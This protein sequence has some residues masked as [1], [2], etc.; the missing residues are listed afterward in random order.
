MTNSWIYRRRYACEIRYRH[1]GSSAL[2]PHINVNIDESVNVFGTATGPAVIPTEVT[3]LPDDNVLFFSSMQER[4]QHM[5][6]QRLKRRSKS[7]TLGNR[8]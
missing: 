6:K 7:I 8:D 5:A 3:A 4:K 2:Y 1:G